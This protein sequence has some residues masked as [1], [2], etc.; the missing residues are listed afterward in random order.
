MIGSFLF[1]EEPLSRC[2]TPDPTQQEIESV[3]QR[4]QAL[5]NDQTRTPDDDPVHI[6]VAWHVITSSIGQGYLTDSQIY[7]A[8]DI[9]NQA[10]NELFNFYF[11][12]GVITRH[13]NDDWFNFEVDENASQG[14]DEAQMRSQTYTDPTHYY[15]IWS[16]LTNANSDGSITPLDGTISH[17]IL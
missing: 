17:S 9:L 8:V 13:E 16:I 4:V 3:N 12:V 1:S 15:N 2:G 5:L 11:T 6:Q 10:Y 14:F 7:D